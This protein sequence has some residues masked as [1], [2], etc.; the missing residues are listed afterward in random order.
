MTRQD[1]D[2]MLEMSIRIINGIACAKGDEGIKLVRHERQTDIEG[3][4][5]IRIVVSGLTDELD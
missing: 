5:E 4:D 2:A 3:H 1:F